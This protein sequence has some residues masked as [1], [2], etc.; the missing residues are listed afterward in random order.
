MLARQIP[1]SKITRRGGE[2]SAESGRGRTLT[3]D[4]SASSLKMDVRTHFIITIKFFIGTIVP[5]FS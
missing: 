1:A 3:D 4:S 5:V 2:S